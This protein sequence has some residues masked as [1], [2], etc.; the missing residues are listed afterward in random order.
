[1]A[2][3]TREANEWTVSL[4]D[5]AP[6]DTVLDVG[7]GPGVGLAAAARLARDGLVVGVDASATMVRQARRRNRASMRQGRVEIHLGDAARLPL[8]DG[9][10]TK[11]ASLDSL[12][13]W[14]DPVAVFR[15]L[16]RVLV[17][18]GRVAVVAM[19]RSDDPPDRTVEPG[20]ATN[21]VADLRA[22]GF[23]EVDRRRREFGGVLHRAF[24]ASRGGPR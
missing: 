10:F 23:G 6:G 3:L 13:F 17:P 7:C 9:R 14:P 21:V 19:A 4:L 11:A 22:A 15:E 2:R 16:H 20:W 8:P 1:M 12:Q 24:L 18:G 5:V